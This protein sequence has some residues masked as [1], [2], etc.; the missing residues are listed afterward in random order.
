[1]ITIEL[2]SLI[3]TSGKIAL[4]LFYLVGHAQI[5]SDWYIRIP[6]GGT[7]GLLLQ[8]WANKGFI[9]YDESSDVSRMKTSENYIDGKVCLTTNV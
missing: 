2:T 8:H 1:M 3:Y 7:V 5:M 9:R 6:Y 4:Y